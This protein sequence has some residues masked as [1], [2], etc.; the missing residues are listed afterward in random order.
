MTTYLAGH[1]VAPLS[2]RQA[3]VLRVIARFYEATGEPPSERYLARR[4]DCCLATVQ[5]HVHA[6][7]RKGWLKCPHP[8]GLRCPHVD[9]PS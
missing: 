8:S 7:Y 5:A 6:L 4:L 3:E 9:E 1:N 2:P